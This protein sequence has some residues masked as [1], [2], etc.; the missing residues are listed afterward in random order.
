MTRFGNTSNDMRKAYMG[1]EYIM[2]FFHVMK[3]MDL[4]TRDQPMY[5]LALYAEFYWKIKEGF[6][7]TI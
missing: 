6:Y 3:K 1:C 7:G 5:D 4:I 2:Q